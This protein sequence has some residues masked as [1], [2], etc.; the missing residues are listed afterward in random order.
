M[1]N[2][3]LEETSREETVFST[4]ISEIVCERIDEYEKSII[5]LRHSFLG[6]FLNFVAF[7]QL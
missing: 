3:I 7:G 1:F 6:I 4:N 5:E 2:N